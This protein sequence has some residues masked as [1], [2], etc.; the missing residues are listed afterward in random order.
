MLH[1]LFLWHS[2]KVHWRDF[3]LVFLGNGRVKFTVEHEFEVGGCFLACSSG[4]LYLSLALI[5]FPLYCLSSLLSF[6]LIVFGSH[7]AFNRLTC[8]FSIFS[9]PILLP[10]VLLFLLIHHLH[11][12]AYP[13]SPLLVD[14]LLFH[15]VPLS[16]TPCYLLLSSAFSSI[17]IP[18][19]V[20]LF[21]ILLSSSYCS[22]FFPFILLASLPSSIFC[23]C[24]IPPPLLLTYV[25]LSLSVCLFLS[26]CFVLSVSLSLLR[27]SNPA[28]VGCFTPLLTNIFW[29]SLTGHIDPDGR[30]PEHSVASAG[31]R[32]LG[33]GPGNGEW[34]VP[35]PFPPGE[36]HPPV[37]PVAPNGQRETASRV[38]RLSA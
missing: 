11:H 26:V 31:H 10:F 29:L 33:G 18:P 1:S 20:L 5:A 16:I 30:W 35:R 7:P 24:P 15:L 32:G 22:T 27:F 3:I 36:L 14:P 19:C 12:F 38:V 4:F 8:H 23:P 6:L 34:P 21:P 2:L 37:G 13:H 17:P 28:C 25:C 9:L